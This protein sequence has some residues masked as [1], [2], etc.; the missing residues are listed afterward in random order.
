MDQYDIDLLFELIINR[1]IQITNPNPNPPLIW[2][3]YNKTNDYTNYLINIYKQYY[4]DRIGELSN[5]IMKMD[6]DVKRNGYVRRIVA[7]IDYIDMVSNVD[8]TNV[9]DI[10]LS[11]L[12]CILDSLY[13]QFMLKPFRFD[14]F[15]SNNSDVSSNNS[16]V[17]SN[18]SDVR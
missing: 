16:D 17:R 18:N 15:R 1:F 3:R 14:Y 10:D 13:P 6:N 5:R 2:I 9:F 12:P 8:S 11:I 4:F 7:L